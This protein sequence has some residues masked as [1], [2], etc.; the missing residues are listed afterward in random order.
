VGLGIS[1]FRNLRINIFV[2]YLLTVIGFLSLSYYFV[3]ILKIENIAL[4]AFVMLCVVMLSAFFI[5]KLAVE[6][7]ADYVG[8][9]QTLS[10][11]TL[12][13]LNLPISTITTNTQMLAKNSKEAKT[14]KRIE[15]IENACNMLQER[16]NELDY[17]IKM[18]SEEDVKEL[19][20]VDE[21]LTAR[22]LFLQ[23]LYPHIDFHL[24]LELLEILGDKTG[25]SK[26][27]DNLIDNGVKYSNN[28]K[29]IAISLQNGVLCIEDYGIGMD[30]VEL[31]HIFDKYYQTNRDTQGFG[32]G[33]SLVKRFCDKNRIELNLEST[34][35]VGTKVKLKL[36]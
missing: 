1:L 35:N 19:F 28:S 6:P 27:I 21:L 25:L 8:H 23:K 4:F 18:Q 10:K 14:L 22:V 26:V 30:E 9:L 2:Y 31:I 11:E 24:E 32:I 20:R 12:H 36:Q 16:Y 5:A 33:L 7:L 29:D 15:R 34:K 17:L 3:V 13:E